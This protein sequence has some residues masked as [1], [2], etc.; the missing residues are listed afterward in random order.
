MLKV[1][2]RQIVECIHQL[3]VCENDFPYF[4]PD[5]FTLNC[6]SLTFALSLL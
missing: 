1:F 6:D 5:L 2:K 4:F 3:V